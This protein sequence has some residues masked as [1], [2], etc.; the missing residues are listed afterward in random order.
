MMASIGCDLD[1]HVVGLREGAGIAITLD[2]HYQMP[3]VD[4][5]ARMQS[6]QN[7]LFRRIRRDHRRNCVRDFRLRVHVSRQRGGDG[8][9][10]GHPATLTL[11]DASSGGRRGA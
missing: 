10:S 7:G 4:V 6:A 11:L 3:G 1:E 8:D 2:G 5:T 9:Y